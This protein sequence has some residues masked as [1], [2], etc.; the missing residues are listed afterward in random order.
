MYLTDVSDLPGLE[1]VWAD[2][3]PADPPA[4][5]IIPISGLGP[6]GTR[7]EITLVARAPDGPPKEVL[8]RERSPRPLGHESQ[9]VR[10]G[11]YVFLSGQLAADGEGLAPVAAVDARLPYYHVPVK[12]EW[13]VILQ[14][15]QALCGAAGGSLANLVKAQVF[16][17]D[18]RDLAPTAE[19]WAQAFASD[20]PARTAVQVPTLPVPGCT[21]MAWFIG[22]VGE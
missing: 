3:F 16:L 17:T 15:V 6:A 10:V 7:I 22:Y 1:E 12:R 4:R 5:T 9:A 18:L 2:T 20:P 8:A 14:N 21:V 13:A 11:P 19:V